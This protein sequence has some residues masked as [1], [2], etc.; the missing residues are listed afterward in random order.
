MEIEVKALENEVISISFTEIAD[1]LSKGCTLTMTST[2][3][4]TLKN[5][6]DEVLKGLEYNSGI[7][8]YVWNPRSKRHEIVKKKDLL[9]SEIYLRTHL[10]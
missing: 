9:P 1:G 8:E 10:P 4:E 5:Q 6:I 2:E 3:A 7:D